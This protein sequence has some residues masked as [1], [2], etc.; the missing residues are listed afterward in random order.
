MAVFFSTSELKSPSRASSEAWMSSREQALNILLITW[1]E[2]NNFSNVSCL[3]PDRKNECTILSKIRSCRLWTFCVSFSQSWSYVIKMGGYSICLWP[4]AHCL[5]IR[6]CSIV[7][8]LHECKSLNKLSLLYS[9][10]QKVR[11][12]TNC[13]NLKNIHGNMLRLILRPHK[14]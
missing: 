5:I 1:D 10:N 14:N 7:I 3:R 8:G 13:P 9:S 12:K 6:P 4:G 11:Q 2:V